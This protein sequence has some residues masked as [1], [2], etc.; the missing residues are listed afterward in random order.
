MLVTARVD[1]RAQPVASATPSPGANPAGAAELKPG[2][3]ISADNLAQFARYVPAAAKFAV[4]HGF[5][6]RINPERRVEWSQ[7]FQHATEK[8]AAQVTLDSDGY[9][10]NY[11]AGM[12][13]PLIEPNDP[14]AA[15]KIAYNWHMGPFM[16]DDFSI[17]PWSSNAYAA[18]PANA[19]KIVP[20]PDADI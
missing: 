8:Y 19:M 3:V 11:V 9:I 2:T 18:D 1:V 4:A 15:A 5:R 17:A 10:K 7:G 13:F 6:M 14:A 16:P 20:N 12:P